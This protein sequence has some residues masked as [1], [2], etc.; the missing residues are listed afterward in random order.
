[1]LTSG[2]ALLL[3]ALMS[4]LMAALGNQ[5]PLGTHLAASGSIGATS[6]TSCG[7]AVPRNPYNSTS[8]SPT[9]PW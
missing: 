2:T 1:M 3:T 4:S 6:L 5:E 8:S 9:A 7:H